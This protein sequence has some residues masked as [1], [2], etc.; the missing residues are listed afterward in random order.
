MFL[1]AYYVIAVKTTGH[2]Q[3]KYRKKSRG[4]EC[5]GHMQE[6]YRKRSRMIEITGHGDKEKLHMSQHEENQDIETKKNF[7]S[8][9]VLCEKIKR[10]WQN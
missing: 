3:K 5:A 6:K 10:W 7:I 2:M 4:E 8:G 9:K 1:E